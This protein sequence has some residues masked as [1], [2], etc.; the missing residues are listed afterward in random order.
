MSGAASRT[1]ATAITVAIIG[2]IVAVIVIGYF[3]VGAVFAGVERVGWGGF[4]LVVA[5]QLG[6]FVPLGFAWYIVGPPAPLKRAIAFVTGRLMREAASDVLP[7]SQLGG[8]MI[9]A[10]A[11]VLS[12][13][14]GAVAFGSG[15]VDLTFEM[16]AQLTYTVV[17]VGLLVLKFGGAT[18]GDHL[19]WILVVGLVA[20]AVM[21][22]SFVLFQ[23]RAAPLAERIAVNFIPAAAVHAAGVTRVIED[24]WGRPVRLL[25]G[26]GIHVGCWFGA[27]AASWLT[28]YLIGRPLPFVSVVALESLVYA[29]RNAA[30]VVPSGLGVQEGAYA[31]L[32]PLFGLPPEAALAL[33]LLKRARD[34]TIGVPSLV[35]WQVIEGRRPR[36]GLTAD[37]P[38]SGA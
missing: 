25:A 21:V 20:A 18:R 12:G 10:R 6:I 1:K 31:F 17:G 16:L 22:A 13:V 27:A 26:W 4:A 11:V 38:A 32:G 15:V 19:V 33:L 2:A 8:F 37:G 29:I 24:A 14:A 34:I 7:F 9:G 3:K 5:C 28:L 30:F 35:V 23:R 36:S